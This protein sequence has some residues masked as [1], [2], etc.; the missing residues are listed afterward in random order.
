MQFLEVC[1]VNPWE[2]EAEFG[3]TQVWLFAIFHSQHFGNGFWLIMSPQNVT[4]NLII[5]YKGISL[6][7][8]TLCFSKFKA[9]IRMVHQLLRRFLVRN[10]A[11][12]LDFEHLNDE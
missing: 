1:I 5:C 10:L 6:E 4:V 3:N 12:I 11:A 9:L 2:L 8:K 7:S